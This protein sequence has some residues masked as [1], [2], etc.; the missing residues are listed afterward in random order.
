GNLS[1]IGE[2]KTEGAMKSSP[3][4]A[5]ARARTLYNQRLTA[6]TASE[7]RGLLETPAA[8]ADSSPEAPALLAATVLCEYL[9]RWNDADHSH[10]AKA[11]AATK[12][13]LAAD[14]TH[15]LAHYAKG[16]VHR[17]KGEHEAALA[18]FGEAAR[19]SPGF[20]RAHAQRGAE[21]LY[22]GR[23]NEAI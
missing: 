8:R 14:P 21:L 23:A 10:I 3:N 18:A 12:Q 5:F 22:L 17:A 6:D 11:E 4:T 20:A 9:N 15:A 2:P 16:F 19:L 1:A 13:A 7:M